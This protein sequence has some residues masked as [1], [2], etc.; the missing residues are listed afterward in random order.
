M[1]LLLGGTDPFPW[2]CFLCVSVVLEAPPLPPPRVCHWS[3]EGSEIHRDSQ[4]L[5]PCVA[6]AMVLS[7]S[8][9]TWGVHIL[10][11]GEGIPWPCE[12]G[13]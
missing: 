8:L 3:L 4:T 5:R 12:P 11:T 6:M 2:K 13:F 9:L 10:Q 1:G 7:L